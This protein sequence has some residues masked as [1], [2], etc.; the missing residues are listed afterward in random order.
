MKRWSHGT[1]PFGHVAHSH[2]SSDTPQ[3]TML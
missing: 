1:H 2:S 3:Y